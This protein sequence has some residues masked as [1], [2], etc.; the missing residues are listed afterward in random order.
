MKNN[1]TVNEKKQPEM[2]LLREKITIAFASVVEAMFLLLELYFMIHAEEKFTVLIAIALCMILTLFFLVLA[3][4]DLSQKVKE[5]EREEFDELY[6][7]QKASYLAT[8]KYFDEIG[9]HLQDIKENSNF[10]AEDII[11][12]QKAVAKVTISRNKENAEA[13]MN[14]NDELMQSVL[15]FEKIITG[16]NEELLR[17]QQELLQQT[18]A[19]MEESQQS[20]QRQFD[21]LR[22]AL[23]QVQQNINAIEINPVIAPPI[24]ETKVVETPIIPEE[25]IVPEEPVIP[26]ET[27]DEDEVMLDDIDS[28]LASMQED[29]E[30]MEAEAEELPP[31]PDLSD[32]NKQLSPEEI[33]ALFA[34]M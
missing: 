12:A 32:P 7:A 16:S 9:I 11:S 29:T 27:S 19:D 17:Q 13:L 24:Q 5:K 1:Q 23:A 33:A 31:M 20:I 10:P 21:E 18:K 26:E 2:S 34:N 22:D 25:L 28:M 6:K 30:K 4:L 8:K 15:G 3:I 14:S